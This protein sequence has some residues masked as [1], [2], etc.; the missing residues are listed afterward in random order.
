MSIAHPSLSPDK[1]VLQG[2]EIYNRLLRPRLE[3]DQNGKIVAIDV[4]SEDYEIG[5]DVLDTAHRLRGRRPN[6]EV[7]LMRVGDV[8][9]YHYRRPRPRHSSW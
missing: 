7:Y 8:A 4:D 9:L 3:P 1:V 6:A 5:T 2:E